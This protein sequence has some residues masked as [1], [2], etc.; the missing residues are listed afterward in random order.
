[1]PLKLE[2]LDTGGFYEVNGTFRNYAVNCLN[3]RLTIL[4]SIFKNGTASLES[5]KT[6]CPANEYQ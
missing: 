6:I 4:Y 5:V 3:A 2:T 1:L